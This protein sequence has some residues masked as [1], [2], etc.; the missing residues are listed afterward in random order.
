MRGNLEARDI[1]QKMENFFLDKYSLLRLSNKIS[2][3]NETLILL[4]EFS[5]LIDLQI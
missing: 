1:V 2:T 5:N 3:L 4:Q